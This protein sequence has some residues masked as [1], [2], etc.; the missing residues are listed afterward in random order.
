MSRDASYKKPDDKIVTVP[1]SAYL[2]RKLRIL[3]AHRNES[4]KETMTA[5]L[6][7]LLHETR[8]NL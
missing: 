1:M 5:A 4:I 6:L 8:I 3:A 2:H 7:G